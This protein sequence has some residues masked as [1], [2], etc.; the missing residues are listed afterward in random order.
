MSQ[1]EGFSV[2]KCGKLKLK[3]ESKSSH[4]KHKKSKKRKSEAVKDERLEDELNHA[5]GW[6]V[7]SFDQ[8]AGTVFIECKEYMYVHG[9]DNGLFV[10]GAPHEPGKRKAHI[11]IRLTLRLNV[12]NFFHTNLNNTII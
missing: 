6:L 7:E 9:L 4:K 10:L 1:T 3:N 2:A 8:V 5:G 11:P 12:W